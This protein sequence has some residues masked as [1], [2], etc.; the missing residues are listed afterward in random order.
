VSPEASARRL[1]VIGLDGMPYRLIRDM[2]NSGVMPNTQELINEGTFRSMTSSIPEI[3]CVSWSSIMT[4]ENPGVHGIYGFTDLMAG[5]YGLR[6]PNFASLKAQP[7]WETRED[8]RAVILNVPS[9]YPARPM[10]GIHISGFVA[11]ELERSIFPADVLD[12]INATGYRIDVDSQKGHSSISLFLED[13]NET[14][15]ARI[16]LAEALFEEED[17]QTFMLVFTG[18]DRLGHFLWA[19]YEDETHPQ[20]SDFLDHLQRVDDGVGRL[21]GRLESDAGVIM[22]SDHGF[23]R[24]DHDVYVNQILEENGLLRLEPQSQAAGRPG[25][26]GL[27]AI[28]EDSVAFALDPGRIYI[29]AEGRFPRGCVAAGE[30][31]RVAGDLARLFGDLRAGDGPAVR[32][33]L[34]RDDIYQGPLIGAA[35]DLVLVGA[36]GVNLRGSFRLPSERADEPFTGKHSQPDAFLIVRGVGPKA[37]PEAP[38]VVDVFGISERIVGEGTQP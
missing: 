35:P 14:L 21:V 15:D 5:G 38:N 29:H 27:A 31:D 30:E 3:S 11:P 17:W 8:R 24:L 34:R 10:N 26:R 19:A 6:F 32:A 13:L 36:K 33:V 28:T 1:L 4:G 25:R 2:A 20:H 9:T 12:R 16:A 37:I 23:E 22:L 18:T 7:F